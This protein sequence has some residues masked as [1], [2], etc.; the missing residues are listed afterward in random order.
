M[1][2]SGRLLRL[3]VLGSPEPPRAD[4]RF[5]RLLA[6][7]RAGVEH[8]ARLPRPL[9]SELIDD[10][11]CK[12]RELRELAP[13]WARQVHELDLWHARF[14]AMSAANALARKDAES[15]LAFLR[16]LGVKPDPT[17][18]GSRLLALEHVLRSRGR[19]KRDCVRW[20]AISDDLWAYLAVAVA[21]QA[22]RVQEQLHECRRSWERADG[23]S[24]ETMDA[25]HE[26]C[27]RRH[28]QDPAELLEQ[29]TDQALKR[30]VL[31]DVRAGG[32]RG[33]QER[34]F[35]LLKA[36]NTPAETVKAVGKGWSP[37]QALQRKARTRLRRIAGSR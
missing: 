4:P 5:G 30:R 26:R 19:S 2:G 28:L 6:E 10:L 15:A 3:A 1:F 14:Q 9:P 18:D 36:G 31:A 12:F 25:P 16:G 7:V 21:R 23:E 20:T 11:A 24:I 32:L 35:Q 17:R 13:R 29:A 8:V 33:D 22:D 34:I 27:G 37:F